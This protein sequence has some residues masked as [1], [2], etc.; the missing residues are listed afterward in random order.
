MQADREVFYEKFPE[1]AFC[2]GNFRGA[3]GHNGSAVVDIRQWYV[4]RHHHTLAHAIVVP[5][6]G[7][8]LNEDGLISDDEVED[9]VPRGQTV[10]S[11]EVGGVA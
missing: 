4:F 3:Y 9:V 5:E 11:A 1:Q 6:H 10:L 7:A 2:K 8:C